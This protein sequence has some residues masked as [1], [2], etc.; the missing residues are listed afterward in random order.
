VTR[1]HDAQAEP[2][3]SINARPRRAAEDRAAEVHPL[4]ANRI[5]EVVRHHGRG[6][7]SPC[8]ADV[9]GSRSL[10]RLFAAGLRSQS[11]SIARWL[12]WILVAGADG[13][14][15]SQEVICR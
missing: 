3:L 10:S 4:R 11:S 7:N 15:V 13:V 9:L 12:V 1:S 8:R 5:G 6:L 2:G 14:I